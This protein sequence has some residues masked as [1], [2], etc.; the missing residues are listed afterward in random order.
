MT[1]SFKL[2][3]PGLQPHP[4]KDLQPKNKVRKEEALRMANELNTAGAF[5]V[6]IAAKHPAVKKAC[7]MC[8]RKLR[9]ERGLGRA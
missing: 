1:Y 9:L 4:S 5:T 6:Q 7:G 3:R 8:L 2:V